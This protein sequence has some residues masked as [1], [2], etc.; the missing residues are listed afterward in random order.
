MQLRMCEAVSPVYRCPYGSLFP[1]QLTLFRRCCCSNQRPDLDITE[2]RATI[3]STLHDAADATAQIHRILGIRCT[4]VYD[5]KQLP[6]RDNRAGA[7]AYSR[8]S[9]VWVHLPPIVPVLW[10]LNS[11]PPA[12]CAPRNVGTSAPSSQLLTYLF[13]IYLL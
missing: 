2:D 9:T 6:S 7:S 8:S 4:Y 1:L 13:I 12:H 11:R 3:T 10:K 5:H